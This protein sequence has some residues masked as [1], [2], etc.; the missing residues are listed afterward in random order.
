MKQVDVIT[1][2]E[3][4]F[5]LEDGKPIPLEDWQKDEILKPVFHDVDPEGHRKV[6]LALI[7]MPKKNGKSTIAAGVAAYGLLGDGE[8][9]VEIYS[10]AGDKEQA[11]IIFK[12]TKKAFERSPL[13]RREVKIYKDAIE[14]RDGG[15]V[16]QV[17]SADAPTAH[18]LNSHFV[19]WDE[20]WNQR[21]YDLWEALT[22][23]PARR[24][25]LHFVVTYA[26]Y[27]EYKGNLLYDLYQR[28]LF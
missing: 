16:Y 26:G 11:A 8:P 18:G 28:G 7:G 20:L 2:L 4:L 22:H 5:I 21:S 15:G 10:C 1:F 27:D 25:P 23:S 24:Q 3:N 12:R 9:D 13:L 14:R 17:L 6:N 19:I